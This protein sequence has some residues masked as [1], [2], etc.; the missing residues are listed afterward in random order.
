METE[1]NKYYE[2]LYKERIEDENFC[3]IKFSECWDGLPNYV[4]FFSFMEKRGWKSVIIDK[5]HIPMS[6]KNYAESTEADIL[7]RKIK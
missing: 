2:Q 4:E 3:V 5:I 6:G 7:F 1:E